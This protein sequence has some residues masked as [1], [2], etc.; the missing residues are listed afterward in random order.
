MSESNV[1]YLFFLPFTLLFHPLCVCMCMCV[2]TVDSLL[3]MKAFTQ[4][5]I[6]LNISLCIIL[7]SGGGVR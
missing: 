5:S 6:F 1:R 2:C 7:E 3:I 4:H